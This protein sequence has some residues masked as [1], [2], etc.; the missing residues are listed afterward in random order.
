LPLLTGALLSSIV[1]FPG[2]VRSSGNLRALSEDRL[3]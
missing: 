2:F 1:Y 3:L